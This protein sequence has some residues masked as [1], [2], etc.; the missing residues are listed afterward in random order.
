M[1]Q[2]FAPK[3]DWANRFLLSEM[4][5]T[6]SGGY[7]WKIEALS[8][9]IDVENAFSVDDSHWSPANWNGRNFGNLNTRHHSWP[10]LRQALQTKSAQLN[11]D[12]KA[13]KK[14]E[15]SFQPPLPVPPLIP[16]HS[17]MA[18][19]VARLETSPRVPRRPHWSLT[20]LKSAVSGERSF[21]AEIRRGDASLLFTQIFRHSLT[22]VRLTPP[23][24]LMCTLRVFSVKYLKDYD[25][26]L[27][28]VSLLLRTFFLL[29]RFC[30]ESNQNLPTQCN[31]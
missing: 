5:L 11:W 22:T 31:V 7:L 13:A 12:I 17:P 25:L 19:N 9:N 21:S 26:D 20:I 10:S 30:F 28:E 24:G 16:G 3:F 6:S 1:A 8:K 18:S 15:I 14:S 2:S 27:V 29:P 23:P 4:S